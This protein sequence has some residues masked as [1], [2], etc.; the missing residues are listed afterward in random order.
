MIGVFILK[1]KYNN[2][3]GYFIE[4]MVKNVDVLMG[5]EFYIYC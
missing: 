1:V 4:V 3:L 2:V 5:E